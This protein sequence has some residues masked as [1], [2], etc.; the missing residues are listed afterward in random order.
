[1][2]REAKDAGDKAYR[3]GLYDRA[4]E[5]YTQA[6]KLN[7]DSDQVHILHSNRSAA[8]LAV[9]THH[10]I[11][12]AQEDAEKTT[13]LKPNWSKGWERLG[14]CYLKRGDSSRAKM[15]LEK[16]IQL[17]AFNDSAKS[18]LSNIQ[19]Q[20]NE[21]SQ[22]NQNNYQGAQ[23]W[24]YPNQNQDNQGAQNQNQN[25]DW[26]NQNNQ[27][28]APNAGASM[29]LR[30]MQWWED[31]SGNAK[32]ALIVGV[33][34]IVYL[35]VSGGSRSSYGGYHGGYGASSLFGPGTSLIGVMAALYFLPPMF[36]YQ[37]FFGMSFFQIMWLVQMLGVGRGNGGYGH[38]RRR[39]G[40]GGLF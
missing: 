34:V 38:R 18:K 3:E 40:F 16:A 2:W 32:L 31:L 5:K 12:L 33:C 21:N 20:R 19:S 4:D 11:G 22:Q 9:G 17:D 23:N 24:T 36:G 6:L 37:A 14:S 28:H 15:H 26:R 30:I 8:R 39:R 35:F 13:Q 29:G 10:K 7:P 25:Q 1:M 27:Q